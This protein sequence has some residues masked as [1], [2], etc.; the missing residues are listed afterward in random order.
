MN[1]MR[2]VLLAIVAVGLVAAVGPAGA[3]NRPPVLASVPKAK[4]GTRV[5][6]TGY[7]FKAH[8]PATLY[9]ES[10]TTRKQLATAN[11]PIGG[12]LTFKLR[13]PSTAP[14][15]AHLLVCQSKCSSRVRLT[16]AH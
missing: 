1:R 2:M 7:F 12:Q 11:V 14:M 3:A 13:L 16:L 4:L 5:V 6:L 15:N 8:K 10:G 9:L